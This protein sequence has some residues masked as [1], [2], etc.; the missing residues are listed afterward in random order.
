MTMTVDQSA[1]GFASLTLLVSV[2]AVVLKSALVA[3]A[4]D[5]WYEYR[6]LPGHN[7]ERM[8]AAD[9]VLGVVGRLLGVVAVMVGSAIWVLAALDFVQPVIFRAVLSVVLMLQAV[10]AVLQG[11]RALMFRRRMA[12]TLGYPRRPVDKGEQ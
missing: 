10:L 4:V 7:P 11:M 3:L 6:L 12:Q 5:D 9:E 8:V 2:L 1:L